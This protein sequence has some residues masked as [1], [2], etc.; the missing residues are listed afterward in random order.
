MRLISNLPR[1]IGQLGNG[2]RRAGAHYKRV[3]FINKFKYFS[4]IKCNSLLFQCESVDVTSQHSNHQHG[5]YRIHY[6]VSLVD[7]VDINV[8][9]NKSMSIKLCVYLNQTMCRC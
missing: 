2:L 8:D 7:M 4:N 1:P 6:D 9:M 5:S 3:H